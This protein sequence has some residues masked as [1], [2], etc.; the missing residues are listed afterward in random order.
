MIRQGT[1][2]SSRRITRFGLV[3]VLLLVVMQFVLIAARW[4][5]RPVEVVVPAAPQLSNIFTPEVLYW[6]PLI[7]AWATAYKVDPNLIATV[8]QIESCGDPKAVSA[9]G[10]QG[11]FQVMPS[12]F[13]TGE[14]MLE[15]VTN[16]KRG[17]EYLARALQLAAGDAGLALAGYNGGH[18]V[19]NGGWAH[20]TAETR[21]YYQWGSGIYDDATKGRTTSGTMQQWL[22]AG[23]QR[24]CKRASQNQM[25]ASDS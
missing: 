3:L 20:W 12:H 6:T 13:T 11:L 21:R 17:M 10:A 7:Y 19:I 9:S 4:F 15:V 25:L 2:L 18:G 5:S 16:G 14:D 1:L 22:Q 23:G 24:L 8:I